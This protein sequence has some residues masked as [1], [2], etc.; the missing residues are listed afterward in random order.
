MYI[1]ELQIQIATIHREDNKVHDLSIRTRP[2]RG[3]NGSDADG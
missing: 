2:I 1:F 3:V